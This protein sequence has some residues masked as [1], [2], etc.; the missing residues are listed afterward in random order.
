MSLPSTS[1][2][3]PSYPVQIGYDDRLLTLGSC[4]A[5]V[6]GD[7]LRNRHFQVSVNPTGALYFPLAVTSLLREALEPIEDNTKWE[8]CHDGIWSDLRLHSKWSHQSREALQTNRAM[9]MHSLGDTIRQ[10]T[11]LIITWGTAYYYYHKSL[12]HFVANCHKLPGTYFEKRL[13]TLDALQQSVYEDL[14]AIRKY[15]PNL[16]ILLTVSPVRHLKDGL[17]ENSI[18]KAT[19]RLLSHQLTSSLEHCYYF[20][21]YEIL[22]DELRDYRFYASDMIHPSETASELI[23]SRFASCFFSEQT[24]EWSQQWADFYTALHHKPRFNNTPSYFAW[25]EHLHSRLSVL[26]DHFE[27]EKEYTLIKQLSA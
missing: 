8:I 20:P 22:V 24:S 19:L 2:R 7:W 10:S 16:R 3:L 1:V 6:L 5:D 23:A 25:I 26:S 17:S 27:V 18:S 14:Q 15:Q 21:S 11:W 12:E 9:L 13:A 4:F